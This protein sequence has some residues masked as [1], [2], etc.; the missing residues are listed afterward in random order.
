MTLSSSDVSGSDMVGSGGEKVKKRKAAL[1][2]VREGREVRKRELQ[3]RAVGRR[4]Q[5]GTYGL[6]RGCTASVSGIQG[7]NCSEHAQ[8][9]RSIRRRDSG[10]QPL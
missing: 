10:A 1:R 7:T 4:G 8:V 9:G 3:T 6:A 2:L 5:K